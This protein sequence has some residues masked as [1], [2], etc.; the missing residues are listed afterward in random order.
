MRKNPHGKILKGEP[1]KQHIS[2]VSKS[3]SKEKWL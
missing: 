2:I 1:K 3:L